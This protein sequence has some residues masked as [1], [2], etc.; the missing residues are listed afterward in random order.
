MNCTISL[1]PFF[2]REAKRLMKRYKSLADD[3][4][5]L[6]KELQENPEMGTDLGHGIRKIRM[7]IGSKGKGKSHGARIISCI[8]TLDAESAEVI[9]LTIYD[10]AERSSITAREIAN[11][12]KKLNEAE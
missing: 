10:K 12:L 6:R 9:L 7:A 5:A 3:L 11:L 4:N 8:V 2:A 1:S